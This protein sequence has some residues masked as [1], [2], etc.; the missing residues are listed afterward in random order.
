MPKWRRTTRILWPLA[1]AIA[2]AV[3]GYRLLTQTRPASAPVREPPQPYISLR[4]LLSLF[5]SDDIARTLR[6]VG[7]P[8]TGNKRER[9]DRLI[10][11]VALPRREEGWS[12]SRTIELFAEDDLRRV[13]HELGI[14]D[15]DKSRMVRLLAA[16]VDAVQ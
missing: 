8:A 16:R 4:E 3:W 9:T 2:G 11:M 14:D 12:F 5:R 7:L 1:A 10:D 6:E 13:C 15:A